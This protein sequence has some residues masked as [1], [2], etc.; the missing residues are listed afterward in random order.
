MACPYLVK[1]RKG[2]CTEQSWYPYRCALTDAKISSD[3]AYKRC[4]YSSDYEECSV[5]KSEH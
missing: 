1:N 3:H 2:D 4:E 5:Y